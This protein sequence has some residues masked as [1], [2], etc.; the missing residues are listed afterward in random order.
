MPATRRLILIIIVLF[1]LLLFI[2]VPGVSWAQTPP[3]PWQDPAREL[4]RKV[5]AITGLRQTLALV[6]RNLSA[7]SDSEVAAVRLALEAE[8]RTAGLRLAAKPNS[9][10]ELRITLSENLQG[11]L[12]VAEV[13]HDDS[14]EVAMVSMARSSALSTAGTAQKFVLQTKLF[15]EQDEPFLD[16]AFL[17]GSDAANA[18]Q[19]VLLEP[20]KLVFV[21][22]VNQDWQIQHSLELPAPKVASRDSRAFMVVRENVLVILPDQVCRAEFESPW[23]LD[24]W[25]RE[26]GLRML[27]SD[28]SAATEIRP[29]VGKN[30][31]LERAQTAGAPTPQEERFY[32]SIA[33]VGRGAFLRII[34]AIDGKAIIS[35][36]DNRNIPASTISGWGSQLMTI[37]A[38][39]GLGSQLL[40][41]GAEDWTEV[42][43]LQAFE[44][45][46]TKPVPASNRIL[47]PGPIRELQSGAARTVNAIVHN[48]KTG[49]Y[50]AY[51][52]TLSCG[53]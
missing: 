45:Q 10:P 20:W 36:P 11:L 52:L 17:N 25:E 37:D 28:D 49:R 38:D 19:F 22:K 50:E 44:L 21:Q 46:G 26:Q 13:P 29:A 48:L 40:T 8:L 1:L 53:R 24:C 27:S 4:A 31:Y 5:V 33:V 35:R 7:L 14:R 18:K 16:L 2:V 39:C 32:D 15:W 34:S 6:L 23:K 42:D 9:T 47:F 43:S 3:S 12:W 41:S 51:T 30:Y